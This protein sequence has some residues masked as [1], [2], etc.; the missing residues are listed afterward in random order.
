MITIAHFYNEI[1]NRYGISTQ[2]QN[3]WGQVT[4]LATLWQTPTRPSTYTRPTSDV[5]PLWYKQND[6]RLFSPCLPSADI[7]E[8]LAISAALAVSTVAEASTHPG[9]GLTIVGL[10]NGVVCP[11]PAAF[12]ASVTAIVNTIANCAMFTSAA[13]SCALKPR[14]SH[15]RRERLESLVLQSWQL[16]CPTA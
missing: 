15:S 2:E 13:V 3:R 6:N 10:A 9:L 8:M 1:I 4:P 5:F 11:T 7:D 16:I 12:R 14:P